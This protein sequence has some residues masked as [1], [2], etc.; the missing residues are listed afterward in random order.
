MP[1]YIMYKGA[2][3]ALNPYS[4]DM[5]AFAGTVEGTL[6]GA[7]ESKYKHWALPK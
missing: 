4:Y 5:G 6:V 7:P 3:G 2:H 1:L